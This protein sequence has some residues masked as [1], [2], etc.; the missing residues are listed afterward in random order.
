MPKIK[1]LDKKIAELI[2]AGEVVE[3]P[4][5]VIKE[6][7][8]NSID[9]GAT[10]ITV[11]IRRGGISFMRITDNGCG[12]DREDVPVAFMRHATSK[13]S[14]AQDLDAINTLGFR[15]EALASI[16]AVSRLEMLTRTK[17]SD[18]G[19]SFKS[20]GGE[21][22]EIQ[23]AGCPAGT[24]IIVRDLFF[25][26]PARMK[27]LKKDVTEG[28]AVAGI[29]DK[30]ALSHPEVSV[31]MIRDGKVTLHTPGDGKLSSDIYAVFGKQFSDTMI[32]VEYSLEH[33]KVSGYISAPK[34]ARA[35]RSMQNFFINGRYVK[36]R[37]AGA[38]LDEAFKGSIMVGR[39]SAC[40]LNIEIASGAVDV[41]VHPAKLEVRFIN[42]RPIFDAVYYGVK[43]A[44][45]QR[46][47]PKEM[48]LKP[49]TVMGIAEEPAK[50][51][52]KTVSEDISENISKQITTT[53]GLPVQSAHIKETGVQNEKPA[54]AESAAKPDKPLGNGL[55]RDSGDRFE[56]KRKYRANIGHF[57]N[58]GVED[59]DDMRIKEKPLEAVQQN[60]SAYTKNVPEIKTDLKPEIEP[61]FI[62]EAFKTYI[63]L[64]YDDE[65]LML[66]DKHA[67]HERLLYEKLRKSDDGGNAQMLL[68]PIAV[69][70]EKNEYSY[71]LSNLE[72]LRKA[73]YEAED[74]GPGIILLRS[75]PLYLDKTDAAASLMEIAGYLRDN[76]TDIS[77][78]HLDWI[79][80]NVA[81]R[82][83]IKGGD[84]SKR[85]ELIAL[86]KQL[87]ENPD[88]RYCPHGRPISIIL[89]RS[90]IE[91][92]FG[93]IV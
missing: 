7:V 69:T 37:T 48:E 50:T 13:I 83:A 14:N 78:G 86:A 71:V 19:T 6:L 56:D 35:N 42:E 15:G 80:H 20:M 39:F 54:G 2:A 65:R 45:Q 77:T 44:L 43:S 60:F 34:S 75:V 27:F 40:V 33:I 23:E 29:M 79:Y 64:Q 36:S 93:R 67:A 73:G 9:A 31:K 53:N 62:G 68:E 5:S 21:E 17:G 58:I 66:I 8:E 38:A 84:N 3:R 30:I 12:I 70:L 4:A 41:N 28:N 91:K 85:E 92:Q 1:L 82:S 32:P 81:C 11:E 25:N 47:T 57:I 90:E 76:K 46:D 10:S 16:S 87:E 26:V 51:D 55:L 89:K 49:V 74:F 18:I 72:I 22:T 63:I 59:D 52:T 61:K 24:T 88:I